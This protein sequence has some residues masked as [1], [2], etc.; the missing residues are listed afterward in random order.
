MKQ[1]ITSTDL[2][3]LGIKTWAD[4]ENKKC[5]L[6]LELSQGAKNLLNVRDK[7]K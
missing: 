2:G 3:K 6:N 7:N 1:Y 4:Y 5:D